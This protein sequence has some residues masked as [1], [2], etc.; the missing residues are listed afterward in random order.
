VLVIACPCAL[1]L[2]TPT[3]IMVSSGIGASL[4]ILIKN[5]EV[6]ERAQSID[7]MFFD[8]TGTL[9]TGSSV[10]SGVTVFGNWSRP[11]LLS[12]LRSAEDGSEHPIGKALVK[13]A[14][15]EGAPS[16]PAAAFVSFPGKGVSA[17]VDG[18][19]VVVGNLALIEVNNAQLSA[20]TSKLA[21]QLESEAKTTLFLLV[22]GGCCA[23]I[24][25]SS[26]V[27]PEAAVAVA[28]LKG[29]G[30]GVVMLTG[31]NEGTAKAC[32]AAVGFDDYRFALSPAD[33]AEIVRDWPRKAGSAIGMVGDGVNDA[34]AF[35]TA[36]IGFAMGNAADVV[37]E[38]AD[39]TLMR[40]DL[41]SVSTAIELSRQTMRVIHQNLFWAFIF[42][43]VGIPL[44]ALGM[45]NPMIAAAAMACSSV[46]VV[47]NSLRLRSI[48]MVR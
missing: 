47:S 18:H 25:L 38:S 13:F 36:D 46:A 35:A 20:D 48:R 27:R 7:V 4:G 42:N 22:D 10:V 21:A 24:A 37:S 16:V 43:L 29:A 2:A 44:A 26:E 15:G 41:S 34:P 32:A 9:T 23:V 19:A 39:I 31:D 1:G 30:I 45:L 40:A 8:K 33:K 14:A 28:R 3:A 12:L 17:T 6:L 5:A 11:E